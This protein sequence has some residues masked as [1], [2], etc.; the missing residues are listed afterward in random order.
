MSEARQFQALTRISVMR[1]SS[2]SDGDVVTPVGRGD[3]NSA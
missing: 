2:I 3:P 1:W